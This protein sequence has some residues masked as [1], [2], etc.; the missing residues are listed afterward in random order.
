MYPSMLNG[1]FRKWLV[2]VVV[3]LSGNVTV[4]GLHAACFDRVFAGNAGL[5]VP[6]KSVFRLTSSCFRHVYGVPFW[7]ICVVWAP[8]AFGRPIGCWPL[9]SPHRPYRLSKL[10]F[11]S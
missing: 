10:W 6:A 8:S 7:A 2:Y 11:S 4:S 1:T 9:T 3:V 5:T